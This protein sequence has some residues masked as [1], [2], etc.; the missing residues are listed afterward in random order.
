MKKVTLKKTSSKKQ[1][2]DQLPSGDDESSMFIVGIGASAGGLEA[3]KLFFGHLPANS[4]MAFI[5]VQHL[6]PTHESL[7]TELISGHTKMMVKEIT[8]GTRI[9]PNCVYVIPPGK[10]LTI[11]QHTLFL[12]EL[13]EEQIKRRP[14]DS[15]FVSLAQEQKG[16]AIGIILSGTGTDGALGLNE[17]KAA[18]G[19]AM[20]Q[21]PETAQFDGMPRSAIM[22]KVADCILPPEKMP[23]QLL[24]YSKRK[25]KNHEHIDSQLPEVSEHN[26]KEIFQAIR[27]QTGYDFSNYKTNTIARRISKRIALNRFNTPEEYVTF[28][29][30]HPEEV[31]KLYKEFLI[32]VTS[33]FRNK[34][35]FKSFEKQAVPYLLEKCKDKQ[36]LRAWVC[37]CST[38]EEAYSLAILFKE[39]IEKN[40]QYLKVTIFASDID[41]DAIEFARAGL[42][43]ESNVVN[44][45]AE[46][47]SRYFTEDEKGYQLK[48]EIREM[49]VFAH[50]NLIKDPPFS[51]MDLITCRNLLIYIKGEFQKKIIPVFHYSL[52]NDGLLLLGTSESIGEHG[53]LFTPMDAKNKLFKKNIQARKPYPLFEL[54]FVE[55]KID[56]KKPVLLS[57]VPKITSVAELAEKLIAEPSPSSSVIIDKNN[58]AL[59][60]SGNTGFYLEPP[61]GV[62]KWNILEMAKK[63]LKS[64]LKNAIKK[65]RKNK[66]EVKKNGIELIGNN[67][68]QVINLTIKPLLTKEY[69]SGTLMIIFSLAELEK[70]KNNSIAG[71]S[72]KQKRS[73]RDL[74]NELKITRGDLQTAIHD[75]EISNEDLQSAN[76][77]L[78]STNEELETSREELQSLNEELI[79]VNSELTSKIDQ[80]SRAN[81]D[82]NNLLRSIDVA[83]IYLD[84][85]LKIKRF[86]PAATNLFNL[87]PSDIDR[88][89]TQLSSNL[90]YTTLVE[91]IGQVLKTLE[92]KNIEVLATDG[93]WYYMRI[94]PYRTTENVIEGVLITMVDITRQK[95]VEQNL[96][97]SNEQLNLVMETLSVVPYI[98]TTEVEFSFVGKSCQKV[99]GFLPEQFL[100]KT[101]FWLKRIH[102]DDKKKTFAAFSAIEKKTNDTLTFRWKCNDG[103]Y[104]QFINYMRYIAGEVGKPPYITGVWQEAL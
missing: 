59:Y 10:E 47:L 65:A 42:Y 51:K 56:F 2:A 29:H 69:D 1:A 18:G 26:L 55:R 45:S 101:S 32:G 9:E 11:V 19:L 37:G 30:N 102:P 98:C 16:N 75:L 68:L 74:E 52:N 66:A 12:T 72:E 22:A 48:K 71:K 21:D 96:A 58:D 20:V 77:E 60:F 97:T 78:Q 46:R 89:I 36:E 34:E 91:D 76:E 53:N 94:I 44:I 93:P 63:E 7:L 104:K 87:I 31:T 8:D 95:I 82:L 84:K 57:T 25:E 62:A 23:E 90:H 61:V 4:G 17:I 3:L 49:V 92:A 15:F 35:V 54:P 40:K 88:P 14:I 39:A 81:N 103:N 24:Y 86:T 13:P 5:I 64:V 6:D 50:H 85:T 80:L 99:T 38:G 67:G 70:T 41:D 73:N 83:T 28:L 27:I 79:T 100:G 33:F 43:N